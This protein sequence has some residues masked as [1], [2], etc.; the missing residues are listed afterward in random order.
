MQAVGSAGSD[1]LITTVA[2]RVIERPRTLRFGEIERNDDLEAALR[3]RRRA[4]LEQGWAEEAHLSEG[5]ERDEFDDVAVHLGGWDAQTLI[6]TARLVFPADGRPLPTEAAFGI[7]VE[8]AG[9]VVDLGRLVVDRA[10]RGGRLTVLLAMLGVAWLSMHKRGFQKFCGV[11]APAM[12]R[13]YGRMGF[14][15]EELAPARLYWGQ[16][17]FPVRFDLPRS[18]QALMELWG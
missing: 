13:L 8:P 15:V 10:Y 7:V 2:N 12:I 3:L 17:R 9:D 11:D 1:A 18:A 16:E 6:G 14:V 4:V 5:S